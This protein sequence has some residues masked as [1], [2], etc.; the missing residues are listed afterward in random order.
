MGI[1]LEII[2]RFIGSLTIFLVA[3]Y[4]LLSRLNNKI[5]LFILLLIIFILI[6][7]QP[8]ICNRKLKTKRLKICGDGCEL[9]IL[10]MISTVLTIIF[11][12]I[13]TISSQKLYLSNIVLSIIVE[14]I[15]FWNGII[16]V[17]LTSVQ[18]GIRMRVIGIIT[19]LIPIVNVTVLGLIINTVDKEV[20]FENNRI[21]LNNK[22]K[23]QE[24]CK[25][26][27]PI[28]LV[29]GVFFRDYR[30]FNYWGRIP[31]D[32]KEN[33]AKIF[34]GNHQ[35]AAS[36]ENSAK[37]LIIRIKEIL[38][39][40]GAEKVNVIA[41]SKGGLDIRYAISMLGGDKYIASLTTISTPHR[42]CLFA[43][44]LLDKI[45]KRKKQYVARKY[46]KT[47][48]KLGDTN[49][50]F[51][52][53]V[54]DLTASACIKRN[55]FVIDSENV[56]Y[57]SFGSKLNYACGGRFPLNFSYE[58]VRY[59]DG[60]NDGL[61]GDYS[62]KWGEYYKLLTV[63]GKRGISHGDM[64]DSNRENIDEFDVREF[65][66]KLVNDLKRKGF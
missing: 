54:T 53:A 4:Y 1:I 5:W 27:Y 15:V 17:Y 7:F 39:A 56:Y 14:S 3:N 22:R 43:D 42:G 31:K 20:Y 11:N 9:L 32:L 59:F 38:K 48:K 58:L 41:H 44:Y 62:F 57:Q 8:S 65:Y 60:P 2:S 37:E 52:S 23:V 13:I 35:S 61:V 34:Y 66:V 24:L 36:V 51:I 28:M 19:W 33:G 6:N 10:F 40:T 50:D 47:L 21:I 63:K 64:V 45:P 30:Y 46:N 25:T 18:L 29:H 16:R 49:P 12:I 55:E 26:R